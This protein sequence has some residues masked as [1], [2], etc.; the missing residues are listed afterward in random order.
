LESPTIAAENLAIAGGATAEAAA[1]EAAVSLSK[2][3]AMSE[4]VALVGGRRRLAC[5]GP[6]RERLW[7]ETQKMAGGGRGKVAPLSTKN[8]AG[9]H[10]SFS[11]PTWAP[12]AMMRANR[13]T[14]ATSAWSAC[15]PVLE[16]LSREATGAFFRF[17]IRKS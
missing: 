16:A 5:D 14:R 8:V 9:A 12:L 7:E 13:R 6:A 15:R 17:A 1:L 4:V 3:G 11:E 2:R 10:R